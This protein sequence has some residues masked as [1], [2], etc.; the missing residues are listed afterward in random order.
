KPEEGIKAEELPEEVKEVKPEEGIKAEELPEEVKEVKPEEGM[1]AE[2]LP[3]EV[4]E[5]KPDREDGLI[6][7]I[8]EDRKIK[9]KMPHKEEVL[10]GIEEIPR[11]EISKEGIPLMKEV[12]RESKKESSDRAELMEKERN[13]MEG[14]GEK[15][16][17]DD[18][19]KLMQKSRKIS[20]TNAAKILNA[21]KDSI[22]EWANELKEK[23][24]LTIHPKFLGGV[25]LELTKDALKRLKE[26]EEEEKIG[27]I[28]NELGR[29][30]EEQKRIRGEY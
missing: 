13:R 22:N 20:I 2:E 11:E 23:D 29:I 3:E 25:D 10:K 28:K 16:N 9:E 14:I 4:K 26:L 21:S 30:R 17:Q 24:I 1:K 19:L 8:R 12:P 5:V 18:L 15:K 7:K 27:R 6:K